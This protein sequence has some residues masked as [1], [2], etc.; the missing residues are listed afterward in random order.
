MHRDSRPLHVGI[1]DLRLVKAADL[2]LKTG[3][4][5]K[6]SG[7][8]LWRVPETVRIWAVHTD[9]AA[10]AHTLWGQIVAAWQ[11]LI[12]TCWKAPPFCL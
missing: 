9:P 1:F 11:V 6:E 10:G 5:V 8:Q 3:R 12:W 2:H 4:M 7:M